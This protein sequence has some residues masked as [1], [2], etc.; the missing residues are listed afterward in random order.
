MSAFVYALAGVVVG[1][2]ITWWTSKH[3]YRLA[4]DELTTATKSVHKALGVL[5]NL[6]QQPNSHLEVQRDS[7]G[8]VTGL[9]MRVAAK[10]AMAP[11]SSSGTV[12]AS[13]TAAV[14][15]TMGPISCRG[16]VTAVT[17]STPPET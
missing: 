7:D 10:S 17:K 6:T 1:G 8:N 12:S 3:Y 13:Q 16:T 15:S 9:L 5:V 11:F 2:L 4:A 14:R